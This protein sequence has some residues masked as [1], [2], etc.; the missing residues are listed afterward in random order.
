MDEGQTTLKLLVT[1]TY[2]SLDRVTSI[3]ETPMNHLKLNKIRIVP[4][5]VC[6]YIQNQLT[7]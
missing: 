4:P 5:H 1:D 3:E 7:G 6:L 2:N